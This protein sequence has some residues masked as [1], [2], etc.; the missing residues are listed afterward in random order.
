MKRFLLSLLTL[1]SVAGFS[2]ADPGYSPFL[3]MVIHVS[4]DGRG[5][6]KVAIPAV[7]HYMWTFDG[8]GIPTSCSVAE[9][10]GPISYTSLI[11]LP[12][13]ATVAFSGLY[14]D[15]LVKPTLFS[16]AYVDLTGKPT[17]FSGSYLDLTNKPTLFS[18][19]YSDLIGP[20][21]LATVATSGSYNDL[22]SKPTLPIVQ[23]TSLAVTSTNT[24]TWTYPIPFTVVPT[25]TTT[26]QVTSA[27]V[28]YTVNMGAVTTTN[29]T[30]RV[31]GNSPAIIALLGL[32]LL[33]LAPTPSCNVQLIAVGK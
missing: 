17:L 25:V 12:V 4:P 18:G 3:A 13:F 33:Q 32:T 1:L 24:V 19:N 2:F 26:P 16:G 7:P 27:A 5:D 9:G 29:V 11:N 15:L 28:V 10:M 14:A 23:G 8:N 22:T 6:D 30:F 20:P 21:S 31:T